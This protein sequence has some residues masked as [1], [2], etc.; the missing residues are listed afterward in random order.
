MAAGSIILDLLMR[1]GSFETDTERARKKLQALKKEAVQT[2]KDLALGF[3]GMAAAAAGGFAALDAVTGSIAKFQD[4][5]DKVGDSTAAVA[6]LQ[7][8]ADQS[9]VAIDTVASASVKLTAA[10]S[11]IDDEGQGAG[12]ALAALGL[13]LEEFKR[14]NPVAQLEAVADALAGFEDGAG[15]TAVAVALFGKSGA[16]LIPFLNDLADRSEDQ[17][18]LTTEQIAAADRFSKQVA[19]LRSEFTTFSQVLLADLFPVLGAVFDSFETG[20]G[21]MDKVSE[22]SRIVRSELASLINALALVKTGT[23]QAGLVLGA[24]F[25]V[26]RAGFTSGYSEFKTQAAAIGQALR[27][28]LAK[29]DATLARFQANLNQAARIGSLLTGVRGN[30]QTDPRSFTFGKPLRPELSFSDTGGNSQGRG[31][32]SK[33]K[34]SDAQT[35]LASLEKQ[36]DRTRDLT[37]VEQVLAD[38]QSGRLKLSG[39]ITQAQLVAVAQQIDAAKRLSEELRAEDAQYKDYLA[40]QKAI[41]DAGARIYEETRTPLERLA[42]EQTRLN[43]LLAAGAISWDTY[44]RAVFAAQDQ[45]APIAD[46]AAKTG[47]ELDNFAKTAAESIQGAIGDGLVNLLEGNFKSIGSNFARLLVRMV[48]EA[49]AANLARALF[50]Q[51]GT[52]GAFGNVLGA[53]GSALGFGGAKASGGD[54]MGKRAYLVGE[55]GPELFVPRTAGM[56]VPAGSGGSGGSGN[57][58]QPIWQVVVHGAPSQPTVTTR[59]NANGGGQLLIAFKN[60]VRQDLMADMADGGR[61]AAAV[62]AMTGTQRPTAARK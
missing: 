18:R 47:V 37:A 54:V 17:I 51:D 31:S 48:A 36:L 33:D 4:L 8:A 14:L 55:Q 59:P 16:D 40:S 44:A 30:S 7:L 61:F 22:A 5:A 46:A 45:F 62:N 56:I 49:Q 32:G 50:G 60:A 1:T 12:K 57:A 39:D 6:G 10:L 52:G 28:D 2:G 11:R 23:E 34:A 35:Y 24:Y 15:K 38:M 19:T 9:G 29:S 42:T 3:A 53:L 27:D 25:A 43:E 21:K 26:L 13:P 41:A 58:P 20:S